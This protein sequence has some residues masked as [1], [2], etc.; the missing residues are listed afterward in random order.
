MDIHRGHSFDELLAVMSRLRGENGC[1]W[2][3]EQTLE[4]LRTYIVE[5]AYELVDAISGNETADI[6]EEC[7]DL[8]L[9]VVFVSKIAEDE[10]RFSIADVTRVLVE[11]LVRRHPHV[12]ADA[13]ART[14]GQVLRKWEEIKSGEKEKKKKDTSLLAG[15]PEGLPPLAKAARIQSKAAHVGFDWEKGDLDPLYDKVDEEIE[16]IHRAVESGDR[17]KIEEEVGDLLFAAVNLARHLDVNPDS[18]LGKANRKFSERFRI[19]EAMVHD[20]GSPWSSF[21]LEA[22]DGFWQ[23]AKKTPLAKNKSVLD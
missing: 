5:E 6:V 22:L 11:K 16:E 15:V 2:D 10:G 1:P 3:R 20:T 4:S 23:E 14:S 12:F 18:A 19:V 13:E 7:G 9:Q 21:T 8:L 17:E